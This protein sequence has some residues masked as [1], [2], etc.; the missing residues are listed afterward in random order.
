MMMGR[1]RISLTS[2]YN[3]IYNIPYTEDQHKNNCEIIEKCLEDSLSKVVIKGGN[4]IDYIRIG[5]ETISESIEEG[6]INIKT[7]VENLVFDCVMYFPDSRR[8]QVIED[9]LQLYKEK[10]HD[11]GNIAE[12]QL[13]WDGAISYKIML[14]HKVNRL[15]T[16]QDRK[17]KVDDESIEDT[18]MDIIGYS[19]IYLVWLVKGCPTINK[20]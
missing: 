2:C 17:N 20:E 15:L 5:A 19:L 9:I 18:L 3:N 12:K 8:K 7:M 14:E 6:K 4:L 1:E 16:L 13:M 10:N 11:Y